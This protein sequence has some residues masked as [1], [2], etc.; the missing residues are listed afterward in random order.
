[1]SVS[2]G[3]SVLPKKDCFEIPTAEY[4]GTKTRENGIFYSFIIDWE[5]LPNLQVICVHFD[6]PILPPGVALPP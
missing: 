6:L 5:H 1:M 2:R 3:D 4:I